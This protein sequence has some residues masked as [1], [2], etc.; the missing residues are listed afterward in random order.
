MNIYNRSSLV[1]FYE[2]HPDCKETLEKWYHDVKS[3]KW[4]KPGDVTKDFNTARTIKNNR[5]IFGINRN[6]YRLIA[7]INYQKEWLFIKFLGT[8]AEYDTVDATTID[9]FKPK[10]K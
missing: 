9:L 4:K 10:K 2:K 7:E 1:L 3:K 6:D 5:A 8:H